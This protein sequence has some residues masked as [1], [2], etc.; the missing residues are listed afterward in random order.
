MRFRRQVACISV[1]FW[2]VATQAQAQFSA[3]YIVG[4]SLVDTGNLA[5][6]RGNF[7]PPFYMNRVSNGPV[8]VEILAGLLGLEARA[9][10]HL[11]GPPDGT[12]YAV[13]GARAR[14]L[15]PIDLS[16][17]VGALL[18]H[19]GG[20]APP[21]ALYVVMIGGNDARDARD[22]EEMTAQEVIALTAAAIATNIEALAAAG[23][24]RFLV[25]NVPD[26]GMIPETRRLAESTG[27]PD[28][29]AMATRLTE[30]LNQAIGNEVA[31]LRA[32]AGLQIA[33]VDI[34]NNGRAVIDNASAYAIDNVT[35][36]CFL[37]LDFGLQF[38]PDCNTG[39]NLGAFAF[40]DGIHPTAKVHEIFGRLMFAFAPSPPAA[41]E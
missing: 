13:A 22:V 21:D 3:L 16:A 34:F 24:L 25:V 27:M 9:S 17:Q 8:A 10:L 1:V 33:L 19:L 4:D 12:N 2:L 26:L 36:G 38:H 23:A 5:S 37:L 40:F 28:L 15:E 14:G 6:V 18:Q 30:M 35:D 39:A 41:M 29:P 31:R 32:E 11:V 20:V 7:P